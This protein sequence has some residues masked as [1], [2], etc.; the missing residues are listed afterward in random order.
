MNPF[1]VFEINIP[2]EMQIVKN[3]LTPLGYYS[4][5]N[6][7]GQRYE[8]PSNCM[9]KVNAELQSALDD[10]QNVIN[11]LNQTRGTNPI[12]LLK[13]VVLSNTPWVSIPTTTTPA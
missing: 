1:I 5:W 4:A 13:C 2:S 7:N 12:Q 8:F 3:A 10:L 6:S 9:W 11:N